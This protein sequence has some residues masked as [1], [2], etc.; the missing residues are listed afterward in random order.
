M[1]IKRRPRKW[2]TP[3]VWYRV[4]TTAQAPRGSIAGPQVW[5]RRFDE[6]AAAQEYIAA[7]TARPRTTVSLYRETSSRWVGV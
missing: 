7:A 3:I 4:V 1:G 2:G 5:E 6:F